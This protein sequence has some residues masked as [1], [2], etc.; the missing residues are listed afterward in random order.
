MQIFI[1][2]TDALASLPTDQS[3]ITFSYC[4]REE[5]NRGRSFWKFNNSLIEKEERVHEMKKINSDTLNELFI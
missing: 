2:N 4:K 1:E 5:S 3:P